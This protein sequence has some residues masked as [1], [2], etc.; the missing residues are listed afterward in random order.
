MT[1]PKVL[2]L[3]GYGLN[4]EEETQYAFQLAGGSAEIIHI[5]D[6]IESPKKLQ[7]YQILAVPG[8]FAYGDDTGAGN[9][10]AIKLKNHLWDDLLQF[11]SRD[12]LTIGICNGFQII[13]NLGLLP[14]FHDSF[15]MREVALVPNDNARYNARWVDLKVQ[16]QTPWL[17]DIHTLSIPIAHGEGKFYATNESLKK[18]KGNNQIALTYVKGEICEYQSLDSNPNGSLEDIAAICDPS[19]RILGMMPHPERALFF[20]QLPHWPVLKEKLKK[21][22]QEI[23]TYGPGL[24][25]FENGVN[26]FVR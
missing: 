4:C 20:T 24:K 10:Y 8:G 5:N 13:T 21:E 9:A 25:I 1:K 15:G 18:L 23:P 7:N 22:E 3:S 11:V 12:T 6:L 19:G 17:K 26:Y 16:S 14:A 2:V